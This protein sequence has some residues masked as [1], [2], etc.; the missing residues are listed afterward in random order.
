[1]PENDELEEAI[2]HELR[3]F[4]ESRGYTYWPVAWQNLHGPPDKKIVCNGFGYASLQR[5]WKTTDT[6]VSSY[7]TMLE[8]Q[9]SV[10]RNIS[11]LKLR[12]QSD[13][14]IER[15]FLASPC[16]RWA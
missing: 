1:M 9:R 6:T 12:S 15:S 7:E 16:S 8:F 13:R 5:G 14:E 11:L 10:C 4:F 3:S 2:W